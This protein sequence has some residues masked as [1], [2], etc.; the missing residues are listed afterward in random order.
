[1]PMAL[2]VIVIMHKTA[3]KHSVPKDTRHIAIGVSKKYCKLP[4][5]LLFPDLH[6]EM[7]KKTDPYGTEGGPI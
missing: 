4:D 3:A 7:E 1:M 2:K 6:D 5:L